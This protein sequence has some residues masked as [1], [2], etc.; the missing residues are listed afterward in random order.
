MLETTE[1][2]EAEREAEP[3]GSAI[4][5]QI[6]YYTDPLCFW[7]WGFEPQMRRLRHAH[8]GRIAWR[9]R[10]G[11][12]IG[13]WNSF[14]DPINS[15]DQPTQMGPLWIQA[16]YVTG[17]PIEEDL[18]VKDPPASSRPSCLAVKAAG[19]Q[20][21]A[22]A[23]LYLRRL[24]EAVMTEH[25]NIARQDVLSELARE[26]S[27]GFPSLFDADRFEADL[28]GRDAQRALIEDVKEARFRGIGRFPTLV[29]RRPGGPPNLLV[30]WHPYGGLRDAVAK[31]GE[32]GPERQPGTEEAYRQYWTRITDREVEEAF[33]DRVG[34]SGLDALIAASSG[35]SG[36]P[37]PS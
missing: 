13:D 32:I 31:A 21:A 14:C 36:V 35:G 22:A 27:E 16:K 23:D 7:S 24:R 5:L 26:V 10:M 6:T 17:M 15:I 4:A 9:I 33:A 19:L 20:S 28:D 1:E 11:R 8:A 30:G 12:M 2:A 37:G 3:E 18:W 25:R 29:I 34:T